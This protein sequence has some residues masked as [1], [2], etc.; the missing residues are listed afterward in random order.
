MSGRSATTPGPLTPVQLSITTTNAA[1]DLINNSYLTYL[2]P[3]E[4]NINLEKAFEGFDGS[5]PITEL[6]EQRDALFF[7]KQYQAQISPLIMRNIKVTNIKNSYKRR[8]C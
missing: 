1:T 6:I 3:S 4:T 2:V 7:G 8:D 5:K